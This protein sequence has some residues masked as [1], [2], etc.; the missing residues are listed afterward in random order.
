MNFESGKTE[1]G[2][3]TT[4]E[5]VFQEGERVTL[6]K[7]RVQDGAESVVPEGDRS[8]G[9]LRGPIQV[10]KAIL[11]DT[12]ARTSVVQSIEQD[13]DRVRVTTETSVYEL[14]SAF[15][16][17]RL[18]NQIGSVKLPSG[19]QEP[20]L[21]EGKA[22]ELHVRSGEQE[23]RV[24]INRD[25]LKEVLL[26]TGGSV[27]HK[28]TDGRYFVVAKVGNA[29]LP[30]YRSSRGTD[31]K[32]SGEWYPFFGHTGPWLIKGD[33]DAEGSM[34]YDAAI[35]EV[36]SKLNTHLVLPHP[37]LL[38]R[39]F[40]IRKE[41]GEVF[42]DVGKEIPISDIRDQEELK[43]YESWDERERVYIEQMTGYK[44]AVLAG[45]HPDKDTEKKALSNQWISDVVQS[46]RS[47][48]T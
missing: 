39:S 13:N 5:A 40:A 44:P 7:S 42:Y 33:I 18:I 10:G 31:G 47:T 37:D 29:H 16:G 8:T 38:D 36:Q 4:Q 17:L 21:K 34:S 12:G 30:F 19:A 23:V 6:V 46:I 15:P 14:S 48:N 35:S 24:S 11:L 41:S 43:Q 22:P 26:E 32:R 9:V 2:P 20:N 27:V 3:N 45:M 25:E 1:S 28:I